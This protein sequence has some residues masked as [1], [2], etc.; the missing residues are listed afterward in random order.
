M[1]GE[2]QK[3]YPRGFI[4]MGNGDLIQ[5]PNIKVDHKNNAKQVHTIRKKGAGIVMGVEETSVSFDAVVDGNGPERNYMKM[6]KTGEIKQ[7][8]IKIPGETISVNGVVS[9]LSKELP[10]DAEIKFSITFIGHAEAP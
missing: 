5:V 3:K 6:L 10:L 8:R 9:D 1:S 7:L 4:A 2:P